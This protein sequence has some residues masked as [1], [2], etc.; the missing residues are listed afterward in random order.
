MARVRFLR[1]G[2]LAM[3]QDRGRFGLQALG[4]PTAGAAD[5]FSFR[6]GNRLLGNPDGAAAL[7]YW[8]LGPEFE[9]LDAPV[10]LALAGGGGTLV[11]ADGSRVPLL[12]W[13]T[14]T[15]SPGERLILGPTGASAVGYV[16]F[17]GGIDVPPVMGSR[18]TYAR[19]KLGGFQ[20]RSLKPGDELPVTAAAA[21]PERS[22]AE[23]PSDGEGP[24]RVVLGPQDDHFDTA[25]LERFFSEVYTISQ[26]SDRMGK[27]LIGP[28][29]T[30]APGKGADITSDGMA[31]GAIQVP[32]SGE[33]IVMLPDRATVGGYA[34]LGVVI[35]A[36]LSRFARLKP[37]AQV[38]FARVSVEEA[39]AALHDFETRLADIAAS[40]AALD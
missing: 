12:A 29:L 24:F 36:D 27:R 32:G 23:A 19:A 16:C 34:K 18:S 31:A 22:L 9:V 30:F 26:Q 28:A 35:G 25:G 33:P 21:G 4:I 13:R 5:A 38:R 11:H 2:P 6:L 10:R 39:E 17:A 7:E 8:L 37:G 1:P 3:V 40:A 14:A 15:L 20:G